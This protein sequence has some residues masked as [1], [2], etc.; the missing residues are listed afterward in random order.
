MGDV[1]FGNVHALQ[2]ALADGADT[3]ISLCRMGTAEVP[4]GVEHHT[5]GLLD[6]IPEENPNVV[7]L[8]AEI[9]DGLQTMVDE[10][11]HVF[12]HCVQAQN[13]TPA[14]AA[15]DAAAWKAAV[16]SFTPSPTTP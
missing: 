5:L 7:L 15:A 11:R 9:V 1:E 13:R 12:V 6:T 4:A 14:V 8:L 3:V 2:G 10:G 16:S